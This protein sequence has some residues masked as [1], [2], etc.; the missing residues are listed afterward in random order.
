MTLD[1]R[2]AAWAGW[3]KDDFWWSD[4]DGL[5]HADAPDYDESRDLISRDVLPKLTNEQW[6]DLDIALVK[7][8]PA[9]LITGHPWQVGQWYLTLPP[10]DLAAAIAEVVHVPE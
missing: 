4:Q 6:R 3:I 10:A 2:L 1:E 8:M 9:G 7:M 5:L